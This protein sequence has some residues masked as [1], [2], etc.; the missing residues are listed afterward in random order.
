M[1]ALTA[2]AVLWSGLREGRGRVFGGD[3]HGRWMVLWDLM[4]GPGDAPVLNGL[5]LW[6]M[7]EV[8]L[9]S[10]RVEFDGNDDDHI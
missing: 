9:E 6:E 4:L 8:L 5:P 3:P 1:S 10:R 7:T 2:D